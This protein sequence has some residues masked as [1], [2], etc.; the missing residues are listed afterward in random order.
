MIPHGQRGSGCDLAVFPGKLLEVYE[1]HFGGG[2]AR[3]VLR[4]RRLAIHEGVEFGDEAFQRLALLRCGHR[5]ALPTPNTHDPLVH[6][7]CSTE[8]TVLKL[9]YVRVPPE[10]P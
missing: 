7:E 1:R 2:A 10:V 9:P 4:E 3:T 6:P 8:R 5:A